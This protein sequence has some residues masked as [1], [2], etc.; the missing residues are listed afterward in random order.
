[1]YNRARN[2]EQGSQ[3]QLM[4]RAL[5]LRVCVC[6]R[7]KQSAVVERIHEEPGGEEHADGQQDHSKVGEH[8]RVHRAGVSR[9]RLEFLERNNI[10]I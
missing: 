5:H 9:H 10:I 7:H 1:M 2:L 4:W 8:S 6:L 3:T